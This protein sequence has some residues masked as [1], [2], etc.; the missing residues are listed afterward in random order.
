MAFPAKQQTLKKF[1]SDSITGINL[2]LLIYFS[3]PACAISRTTF[4]PRE[5]RWAR[6]VGGFKTIQRT[7][8]N[9]FKRFG[10]KI[11]MGTISQLKYIPSSKPRTISER[12]SEAAKISFIGR[13][14]ELTIILDAIEADNPPFRR[15]RST[16]PG[17]RQGRIP[18][19]R[20]G[21]GTPPRSRSG[22]SGGP[23][24]AP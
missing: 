6:E 13:Q 3:L 8:E 2:I 10:A 1:K 4:Q 21:S 19:P 22:T 18:T 15:P 9:L 16:R 14:T 24:C 17:P 7:N 5:F 23:G 12:L 11:N 20:N